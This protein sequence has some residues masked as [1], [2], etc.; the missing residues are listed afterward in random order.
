MFVQNLECRM[1]DISIMRNRPS[2]A[3][4]REVPIHRQFGALLQVYCTSAT[5]NWQHQHHT[6]HPTTRPKS[7]IVDGSNG[8]TNKFMDTSES[9]NEV[10]QQIQRSLRDNAQIWANLLGVIGGALELPKCRVHVFCPIIPGTPYA[11]DRIV[12]PLFQ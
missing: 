12:R 1:W 5:T 2:S 10:L 11:I 4:V 8:Q 7:M 6:V 3:Q 9:H